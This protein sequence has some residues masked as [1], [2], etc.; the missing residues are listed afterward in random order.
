MAT[1]ET[2]VTLVTDIKSHLLAII[3]VAL[4]IFGGVYGVD[5]LIERHDARTDS[6]YT[7]ILDAQV[8]QTATLQQQ[9]TTDEAAWSKLQAQLIAQNATL[10][11][12]IESRNTQLATQIKADATLSAVQVAAQLVEQTKTTA[13][14]ITV[15]GD[16]I[17]LDLTSAR[18]I[19]QDLDTLPVVQANLANTQTQLKNETTIATNAQSDATNEK[20]IIVSQT[21]QLA[22]QTKACNAQIAS[23]KAQARK[24][25]FK[26]FGLGFVAGFFSAHA[27]GF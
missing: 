22:D 18:V 8:K 25:K 9:L 4:L 23:V 26:W 13:S 2:P 1:T 11:K 16:S 5:S 14:D 15:N 6:K 3:V 20:A 24:S 19:T 10:A 17:S 12:E 27:I 7:A 21:S